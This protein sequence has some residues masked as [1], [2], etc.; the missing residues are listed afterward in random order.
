MHQWRIQSGRTCFLE[1]VHLHSLCHSLRQSC[2][3]RGTQTDRYRCA[4]TESKKRSI[5]YIFFK[6]HRRII[7]LLTCE[8][9]PPFPFP[10]WTLFYLLVPVEPI[11]DDSMHLSDLRLSA[12]DPPRPLYH[13]LPIWASLTIQTCPHRPI[14][15][16]SPCCSQS[17]SE[18]GKRI[19]CA[20]SKIHTHDISTQVKPGSHRTAQSWPG[21]SSL[22]FGLISI[23]KYV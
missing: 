1:Q 14:F 6:Y 16:F 11:S 12:R 4:K 18:L 22:I 13:M 7:C 9:G 2:R 5:F 3:Q 8:Q 10:P 15:L 23:V 17:L 19:L 21:F 20:P